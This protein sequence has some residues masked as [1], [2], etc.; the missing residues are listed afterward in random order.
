M[1]R[2][3]LRHRPF[4]L[5]FVRTSISSVGDAVVPV[6]LAFA[7]LDLTGS[8]TD[9]GIVLAAQTVPLMVFVLLGGV[10]ADRLPRQYVVLGAD[11]VRAAAQ[12]VSAVLL[13][14]GNARV[15]Q[16][17]VL[18]AV[19]GV[20]RGFAGPALLPLVSGAVAPEDRQSANA[21]FELSRNA[22]AVLGPALAGVLVAGIGA[23]WALAIDAASFAVSVVLLARLRLAPVIAPTRTTLLGELRAGWNA[24]FSR[25]WLWITVAWFTVFIG[26]VYAP[27]AVL[28]PQVA[29]TALGGVGAWAAISTG[30]GVGAVAGGLLGIRWRPRH[31]LRVSFLVFLISGPPL[32]VLLGAHA[33]VPVLVVL[34]VLDG[35]AGTLFN[36]FWYTAIQR[37]VP[38]EELARVSSWDYLGS[39]LLLPVGQVLA[40]PVS[41]AIGLSNTLYVTGG[42]FAVLVLVVLAVPA[43]RDFTTDRAPA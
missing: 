26:F 31:S 12:G 28:G 32:W 4:R 17:A 6:A 35:A 7:V 39:L 16:L 23:G 10:W 36:L 2:G 18:Q 33:P 24:F 19:Y 30:A 29:R 42:L 40:G 9:L 15:W 34:A 14:T 22:A 43:V 38:H 1:N 8:A 11:V 25:P 13:V 5:L 3:A 20:A 41:K 21:L 27:Y 37:E